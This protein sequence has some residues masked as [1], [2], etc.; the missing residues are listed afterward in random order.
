M[1][2]DCRTGGGKKKFY[3]FFPQPSSSV[4]GEMFFPTIKKV[5]KEKKIKAAFA[6][7]YVVWKRQPAGRK[8]P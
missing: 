4:A 1:K 8:F 3:N 6:S 7:K 2:A 5:L